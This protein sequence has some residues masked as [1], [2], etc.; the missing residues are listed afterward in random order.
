MRNV[1]IH[2]YPVVDLEIVWHTIQDDLPP[3]IARICEIL[4]QQRDV[5]ASD[6]S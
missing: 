5:N 6:S 4:D 3:T 1:L 2:D